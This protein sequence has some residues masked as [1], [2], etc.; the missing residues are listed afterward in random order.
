YLDQARDYDPVK[1]PGKTYC[2]D[3]GVLRDRD[4]FDPLFFHLSPRDAESMNLHQRLVLQESW[5]AL[6]DAGYN[7]RALAESA[8][9]AFVGSEPTGYFHET[10]TGA[11][12]AI[13]ASRLSYVLDLRGPAL[14]VNTGCSSSGV[15]LHMACESLHRGESTLALAGGVFAAISRTALIPLSEIEMLSAS[16]R[17]R[18]FDAAGDGMVLSEGVGM[19]VLKRLA[20]AERDGDDIYGVIQ[21]SG[22]NQD[23]AS[24][25]ITAPNGAAQESLITEIYERHGIDPA[26]ISYV[27]AHGT[28][29]PLGDPIEANALSRAFRRFTDRETYCALGSAKA[30]IGHT[31]ASA[32]VIGLMKVLMSMRH[33]RIPGL[34]HFQK[35]NSK[36][37]LEGS[38][39]YIPTATQ[40]WR[41][42]GG[43][44]LT[45][46]LSGFGHSGTNVHFVIRE[47]EVVSKVSEIPPNGVIVPLSAKDEARLLEAVERLQAFLQEEPE[48][49]LVRL[50]YTLQTGREAMSH[51]IALVVRSVAELRTA[52][53]QE[54]RPP[55]KRGVVT[56]LQVS[57]WIAERNLP[58][59]AAAWSAGTNVSWNK[60][61]ESSRPRRLL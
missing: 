28:G 16:G 43:Q 51:R 25:G 35:L 27:E 21:A 34:P 23:G 5:R 58:E 55:M 1:Q 31:A 10:F 42:S 46:A 38:P 50:A 8:T 18:T 56:D 26:T 14:V 22:M 6:E 33:R 3:G 7:P 41:P 57:E 2:R 53:A 4:C 32:T 37:E 44:P 48:T 17:C 49:D 29:T 20:D 52:L 24:T 45:A 36:I 13:I 47:P 19:V 11:S 61:H 12:D 60:L 59:L 39:F 30:H 54:V 9:G 40:E 15:A